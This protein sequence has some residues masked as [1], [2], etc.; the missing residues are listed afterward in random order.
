[1]KKLLLILLCVPLIGWSQIDLQK[2]IDNTLDDN[3]I[4]FPEGRYLIDSPLE[5]NG[6][7][8]L[9]I[10]GIGKC[11]ILLTDLWDD[12]LKINNSNNITIHNLHLSH[13]KPLEE[14]QCNGGVI[15]VTDSRKIHISR[16][17][18]EGSGTIG[19]TASKVNDLIISYCY[20]HDNT[21]NAFYFTDSKDILIHHCTIKDNANLMQS[22]DSDI[23]M[24]D[25]TIEDNGGYWKRD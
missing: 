16:C 23:E 8:D 15:D 1:M 5:I 2:L 24:S 6:R 13:F 11:E 17:E 12:V 21:F 18:L 7:S 10:V 3:I 22:Y 9:M 20:V 4:Q 25:N 14:Y 19:V